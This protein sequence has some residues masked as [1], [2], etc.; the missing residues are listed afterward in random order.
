L[1]MAKTLYAEFTVKAGHEERVA[2]MMATR[3]E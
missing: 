2:E 3:P 1:I